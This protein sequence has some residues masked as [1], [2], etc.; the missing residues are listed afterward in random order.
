[1]GVCVCV[2][3]LQKLH[4]A[5]SIC[6]Q[7][8]ASII[9]VIKTITYQC[10][11]EQPNAVTTWCCLVDHLLKGA[12]IVEC[13]LGFFFFGG[14]GGGGGPDLVLEV[15]NRFHPSQTSKEKQQRA[16]EGMNGYRRVHS[17]LVPQASSDGRRSKCVFV[18]QVSHP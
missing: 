12:M 15:Q 17:D 13:M 7:L 4:P 3:S 18:F 16:T 9:P 1:M 8:H 10:R 2:V 11:Q 5:P 6:L 14:V